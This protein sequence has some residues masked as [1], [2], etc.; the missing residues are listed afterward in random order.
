MVKMQQTDEL[1]Q[2]IW[3]ALETFGAYSTEKY[4]F[5]LDGYEIA[6]R[7]NTD[8]YL[9]AYSATKADYESSMREFILDYGR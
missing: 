3:S 1:I 9:V 7:N 2:K 8:G 4:D 6:V 5:S